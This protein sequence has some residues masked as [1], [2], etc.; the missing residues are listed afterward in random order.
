MIL[1]R[2]SERPQLHWPGSLAASG[3][4]ERVGMTAMM[5]ITI[6][7]N[8]NTNDDKEGGWGTGEKEAKCSLWLKGELLII[9][10]FSPLLV[11]T[12]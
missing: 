12:N 7:S 10:T 2:E 8:D 11:L 3:F 4:G 9:Y 1:R 6:I 5:P